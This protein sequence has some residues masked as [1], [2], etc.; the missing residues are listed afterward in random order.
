MPTIY[1]S[2]AQESRA[3][4][5]IGSRSMWTVRHVDH[6][7]GQAVGSTVEQLHVVEPL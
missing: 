2:R 3:P 7:V 5:A 4:G 6:C 1:T